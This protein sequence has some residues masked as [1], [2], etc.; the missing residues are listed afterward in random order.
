MVRVGILTYF[1]KSTNYGG[2]L[3]SYA[4]C[5]TINDMDDNISAEQIC[6]DYD[7]SITKQFNIKE[8]IK[9]ILSIFF[10]K[11]RYKTNKKKEST[12]LEFIT[13]Y[14]PHSVNEYQCNNTCSLN[15]IYDYF[16]TGSDQVWNPISMDS[17][18]FLEF[19]N[20]G[21]RKI[22]YAASIG[23][24]DVDKEKLSNIVNK[25]KNY[26]AISVREES[27]KEML[28][29]EG[30]KNVKLM[31]DPVFLQNIEQWDNLIEDVIT[32]SQE[33]IFVYILSGNN[34]I[35]KKIYD[36]ARE[37]NLIIM[38]FSPL[39]LLKDN[40]IDCSSYGPKEF[41]A[42]IKYCN[43]CCTDS[44]HCTAFSLMYER[45]F[46]VFS[47][48]N[49]K[50]ITANGRLFTLLNYV[51]MNNRVIDESD[52][53][54]YYIDKEIKYDGKIIDNMRDEAIA[55]LKKMLS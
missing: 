21:K 11:Y 24:D 41:V 34:N 42:Y 29:N 38:D 3:Q 45:K 13:K 32:K 18:F 25:L 6:Y 23:A 44:F 27:A 46:V 49:K 5:K 31:I 8:V 20:K 30:I 52:D 54:N 14:V 15:N 53:I 33:Y 50:N 37:K 35:R 9:R 43:F 17:N 48:E 55:F 2:I 36:F 22:S 51:G 40:C 26:N 28:E 7:S 10:K 12:F 16:I 4:L 1:W 39:Q 19:V 47:R